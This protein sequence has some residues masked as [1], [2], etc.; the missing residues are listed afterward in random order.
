VRQITVFTDIAGNGKK[1]QRGLI[2]YRFPRGSAT[3][4]GTGS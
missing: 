1:T 3:Y 2:E 4:S